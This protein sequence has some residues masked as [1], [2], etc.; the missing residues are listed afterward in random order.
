[1]IIIKWIDT[2]YVSNLLS[3]VSDWLVDVLLWCMLVAPPLKCIRSFYKKGKRPVICVYLHNSWDVVLWPRLRQSCQQS[4]Q[5]G[6]AADGEGR[7][8]HRVLGVSDA[9]PRLRLAVC[10]QPLRAILRF[11]G[12]ERH[13]EHRAAVRAVRAVRGHAATPPR[14]REGN[15]TSTHQQN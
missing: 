3:I 8:A 11:P 4:V 2:K 9:R 5:D 6:C 14:D 13:R 15:A 12:G 7:A 1:M 10:A